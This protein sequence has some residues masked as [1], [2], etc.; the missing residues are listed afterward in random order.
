MKCFLPRHSEICDEQWRP[1]GWASSVD[2]LYIQPGVMSVPRAL[3]LTVIAALKIITKQQEAAD[4]LGQCAAVKDTP[5]C[6]EIYS[7]G[8][9]PDRPENKVLVLPLKLDFIL[10]CLNF[11]IWGLPPFSSYSS[12]SV[13]LMF[14]LRPQDFLWIVSTS[15]QFIHLFI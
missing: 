15:G 11:N 3:K 7:G 13:R 14:C 6:S 1:S 5:M 12:A 10:H 4:V 8:Q 9:T 2:S